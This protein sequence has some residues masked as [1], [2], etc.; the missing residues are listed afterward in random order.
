MAS[1]SRGVTR[2]LKLG[3]SQQEEGEK[4]TKEGPQEGGGQLIFMCLLVSIYHVHNWRHL[5][6]H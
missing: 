5:S 3:A 6:E 2:K 4:K 1:I